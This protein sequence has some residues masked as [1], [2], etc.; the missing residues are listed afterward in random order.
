MSL[1]A[2]EKRRR[3]QPK[4]LQPNP[5]APVIA[6]QG[7]NP[8]GHNCIQFFESC[9]DK[10][11]FYNEDLCDEIATTIGPLCWACNIKLWRVIGFESNMEDNGNW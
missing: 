4:M 9:N 10:G 3:L 5:R 2:D 7:Q 8:K 6:M 11:D 1:T